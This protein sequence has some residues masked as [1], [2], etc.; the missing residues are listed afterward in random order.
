MNIVRRNP[1][2]EIEEFFNDQDF[3][4]VGPAV[5]RRLV[6]PMDIYQ[7]DNELVVELQIPKMDPNKISVS[8]EDGILTI[9]TNEE[10]EK[11]E[12]GKNYFRKEI[13]RGS[14][15]RRIG[16][17]TNVKEDQVEAHFEDG[18]LKVVMPKEE[19]KH[20]KKIEVKVK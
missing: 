19:V 10:E 6:P 15:G 4:G 17:P 11:I 16:L 20:A 2:K 9:E 8:V 13:R 5:R 12:E 1:F 3:W 18:V 7:T 14:F